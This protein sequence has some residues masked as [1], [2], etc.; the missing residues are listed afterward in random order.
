MQAMFDL[1]RRK[2]P[3]QG[4]HYQTAHMWSFCGQV[5]QLHP[6]A[7][8]SKYYTVRSEHNQTWLTCLHAVLLYTVTG[9]GD[10][11]CG[12]AWPRFKLIKSTKQLIA[13]NGLLVGHYCPTSCLL[14]QT[15]HLNAKTL[16]CVEMLTESKHLVDDF[17][18]CSATLPVPPP[19]DSSRQDTGPRLEAAEEDSGN[20]YE[21]IRDTGDTRD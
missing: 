2:G 17:C 1:V 12:G 13:V 9:D 11:G 10:S 19:R 4:L 15:L 3:Q 21:E 18:C 20:I 5:S 7:A 16:F 8:F 14:T 6:I